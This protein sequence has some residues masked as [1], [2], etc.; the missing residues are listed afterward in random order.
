MSTSK[1][2][3]A[4]T[5]PPVRV[6]HFKSD[7][8]WL[9]WFRRVNGTPQGKKAVRDEIEALR[10]AHENGADNAARIALRTCAL[11]GIPLPDWLALVVYGALKVSPK[12]PDDRLGFGNAKMYAQWKTALLRS[13]DDAIR[14]N[15][16]GAA[17]WHKQHGTGVTK[18]RLVE[19]EAKRLNISTKAIEKI[20]YAS[21]KS[22]T[23]TKKK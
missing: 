13:R 4:R 21:Q 1:K 14:A 7:Q 9:D 12:G 17:K 20:V 8:E 23:A 16:V 3:T 11:H 19:L 6:S 18:A 15:V 2:K 10:V 22:P 5:G